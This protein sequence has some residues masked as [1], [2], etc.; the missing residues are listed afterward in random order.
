MIDRYCAGILVL[1]HRQ[2]P[3]PGLIGWIASAAP[4]NDGTPSRHREAEGRGDPE[5]PDSHDAQI[6]RR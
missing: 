1:S 4:R 5:V 6:T 2:M 3:V